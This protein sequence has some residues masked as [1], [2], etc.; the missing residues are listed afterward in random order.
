VLTPYPGTALHRRMKAQRRI[1][2][3]DWDRYDTR[4]AVFRPARMSGDELERGYRRAYRDFYRWSAI[5]RGASA[6]HD[7]RA[8]VRHL[9]YAAGWKKFEPC[10][11]VVIRARRAGMMVPVLESILTEFGRRAPRTG[12]SG[13]GVGERGVGRPVAGPVST[14]L[15]APDNCQCSINQLPHRGAP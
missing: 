5:A 13:P 9:A 8:A 2:S 4:H 6:H 14:V 1:T 11:D 15:M 12:P 3:E 7:V 10:W